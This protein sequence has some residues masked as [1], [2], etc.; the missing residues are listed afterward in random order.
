MLPIRQRGAMW[1]DLGGEEPAALQTAIGKV[2]AV[3]GAIWSE[4][5]TADPQSY[6]S[7]PRQP[8]LDGVN[9]GEGSVRQFV[10]TRLGLGATVEG[11]VTGKE[12]VGGFQLRAVGLAAEAWKAQKAASPQIRGAAGVHVMADVS[13]GSGVG[14]GRTM[15]QKIYR[16]SR[17]LDDYDPGRSARVFVHLCSAE[18]WTAITGEAPPPSHN[19]RETYVHLNLP[20]FDYFDDGEDIAPSDILATVKTVGDV[21]ELDEPA[22]TP[23]KPATVVVLKDKGGDSVAP[24]EW[25][26]GCAPPLAIRRPASE[27]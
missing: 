17:P 22:F 3:S 20:L 10:A 4:T 6:V 5:L 13:F 11:Q 26:V 18:Q 2:C 7:L 24:G 8:W 27:G 14:A 16:D 9:S 1:L 25:C 21:L 12:T 15:R 19:D 23:T